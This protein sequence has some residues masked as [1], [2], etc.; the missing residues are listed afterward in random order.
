MQSMASVKGPVSAYPQPDLKAVPDTVIYDNSRIF[1]KFR[2]DRIAASEDSLS[3]GF[4]DSAETM[5]SARDTLKAPDSL[6]YTDPF[7]FRYYAA[8]ND[9]LTHKQMRDSLMAA[10]D[11]VTM[12]RL[13][14]VYFSDSAKRADAA[15]LAW[16]ASLDKAAKKQYDF[17]KKQA[18]R[19][20]LADSILEVKDSIRAVRDSIAESRP[21]IL[22]TFALPDSMQY[23]RIVKWNTDR[24]FNTLKPQKADTSYNY[25][26]NDLPFMR[27]EVGATY[28]GT[29]G[30]PIQ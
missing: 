6:R 9:S 19:Q 18:H 22:E 8:I 24:M 21:R 15:F 10:G 27:E 29:S 26:F 7:R 4:T 1:T 25:W 23:K 14:S 13:D 17:K 16:Y 11:I 20:H 28:L 5:I 2:K 30:S 3:D 12:G